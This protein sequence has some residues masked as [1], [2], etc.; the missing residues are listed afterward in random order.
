MT[1]HMLNALDML[2]DR[3]EDLG[4]TVQRAVAD[5]VA[6]VTDGDSATAT[7]VI[8]GDRRIDQDEVEVEEECLKVFA[9]HQPVARDLRLLVGILKLNNDLERIGDLAVN[10]AGNC[11]HID[12]SADPRLRD[13]L[14]RLSSRSQDMLQLGLDSLVRQDADLARRVC[15][16]DDDVDRL[17]NN[18]RTAIQEQLAREE[19]AGLTRVECLMRVISVARSLERIAD[20]ATNIAEDV[21]YMV[22]G[23]IPR[24][25]GQRDLRAW[26]GPAP[27]AEANTSQ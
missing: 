17:Y 15:A 6:S 25:G 26:T 19:R 9:L 11:G 21:I 23:E 1:K 4:R 27:S 7:R 16:A 12:L 13:L 10:I 8:E 5:A 22:T 3:V 24:H 14:Q 20:H 18:L 2:R